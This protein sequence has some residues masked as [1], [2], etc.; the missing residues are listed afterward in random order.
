MSLL[1]SHCISL[2][3]SAVG[4]SLHTP[5]SHTWSSILQGAAADFKRLKEGDGQFWDARAALVVALAAAGGPGLGD[6]EVE[7][8]E[9]C[10]PAVAPLPTSPA[11]MILSRCEVW[12]LWCTWLYT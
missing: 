10:R 3:L 5:P 7:W 9:L 2:H 6:A 8:A 11:N 12:S 1:P 4:C